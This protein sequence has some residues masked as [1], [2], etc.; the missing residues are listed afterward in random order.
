M[1]CLLFCCFV[2][3]C[4]LLKLIINARTFAKQDCVLIL[5]YEIYKINIAIIF[6]CFLVDFDAFANAVRSYIF[7]NITLLNRYSFLTF[8]NFAKY[9][10]ATVWTYRN[11][12]FY[13]T[14]I[15]GGQIKD[16]V[17]KMGKY[18]IDI[19]LVALPITMDMEQVLEHA[20]PIF[21][22]NT[23]WVLPQRKQLATWAKIVYVFPVSTWIA[24]VVF[25]LLLTITWAGFLLTDN[26]RNVSS[27]AVIENA[28]FLNYQLLVNVSATFKPN[29]AHLRVLL[30]FCLLYSLHLNCFYNASLSS[31][32][33]KPR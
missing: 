6:P 14:H 16:E 15:Q 10:N 3:C 22:L 13:Q 23:F 5:L 18:G 12:K 4:G 25:I 33:T 29:M 21:V 32:L 17:L 28:F 7:L 30:L 9:V 20:A 8:K 24:V 31:M 19:Y 2:L 27:L 1:D 26:R 11:D